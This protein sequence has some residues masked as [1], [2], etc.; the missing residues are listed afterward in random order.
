MPKL[1]RIDAT[2][3]S[4]SFASRIN[5]IATRHER[6]HADVITLPAVSEAREEE[7][8][9]R[10]L[11]AAGI[12]LFGLLSLFMIGFGGLY[13]SVSDL[14]WFHAAAVPAHALEAVRPLYFALMKLVGGA[15]IALGLLGGYVTAKLATRGGNSAAISLFIAYS[16]PLLMAAYVAETLAAATGSPTSWHIMGGLMGIDAAA[17]GLIFASR[18]KSPN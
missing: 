12:A 4:G 18:I 1:H 6:L 16:I 14:L 13:A 3:A 5:K 11:R 9:K 15:S 8:M 2:P 10:Y 7:M 17:L